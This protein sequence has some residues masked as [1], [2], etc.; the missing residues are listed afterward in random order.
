M[1]PTRKPCELAVLPRGGSSRA[2]RRFVF[3][4]V[5][6]A[7]MLFAPATFL[8]AGPRNPV[9]AASHGPQ[10]EVSREFNQ[11]VTL[12]AGQGVRLDHRFGEVNMHTQAF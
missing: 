10:E 4:P 12:A 1:N 7:A 5:V 11:T 2:A 6:V 8:T 9:H 3:A